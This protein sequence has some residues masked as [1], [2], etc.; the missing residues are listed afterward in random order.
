M[1]NSFLLFLGLL[2]ILGSIFVFVERLQ[3]AANPTKIIE[4]NGRSIKVEVADNSLTREKGLSNRRTLAPGTGMLFVFDGSAQYGFWM[5][6]M[7]FAIDILWINEQ[8]RVVEIEK[9]VSP[10][11]FPKIFYPKSQILYALELPAGT[12]DNYRIDIGDIV[13]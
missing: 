6:D 2:V 1:K 12:A 9:N 5:K 3:V 7:R 4:I 8:L 13:S 11:T 10:K